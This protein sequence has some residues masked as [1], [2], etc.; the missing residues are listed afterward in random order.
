MSVVRLLD[1]KLDNKLAHHLLGNKLL[2]HKWFGLP[3]GTQ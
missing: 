1:N 2:A 3:L